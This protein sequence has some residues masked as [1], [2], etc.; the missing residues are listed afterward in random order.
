[1]IDTHRVVAVVPA[2]GGSETVP[3]KNVRGLGGKPLVAWPID[4]ARATPA[5][6]RV[7][8]TTDDPSIAAVAREYGADVVDRPASLATDDALVVDALRHVVEELRSEG[9]DADLLVMLEPTCPLRRPEDVIACLERLAAGDCDS[10]ATFT[11]A[12]VNP[13]RIWRIDGGDPEPFVDGADPFQPRQSLPDAYELTGAVYAFAVDALPAEGSS[14]LF[15]RQGAV[16]MPRE[17]SVDIDTE[18]DFAVA[19]TLLA[20]GVVTGGR[21]VEA[22]NE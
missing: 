13:H 3:N 18:L 15:G 19:E 12:A 1:M 5:I 8:V 4:V 22:T 16:T 2:R 20:E 21:P 14:L 6:D 9:E 7:V 11:E 10:V 17:R